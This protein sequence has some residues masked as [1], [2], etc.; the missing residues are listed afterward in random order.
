MEVGSSGPW[1]H[2]SWQR[3]GSFSY[4]GLRN[5]TEAQDHAYCIENRRLNNCPYSNNK[6]TNNGNNTNNNNGNSNSNSNSNSNHN[7]SN[8]NGNSNSNSNSK[9]NGKNSSNNNGNSNIMA[10]GSL[11]ILILV[12]QVDAKTV[13]VI[14]QFDCS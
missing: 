3:T 13:L 5:F 4:F 1:M 6:N 9:T 10:P 11:H 8:N 2:M 12:L 7:T 14:I